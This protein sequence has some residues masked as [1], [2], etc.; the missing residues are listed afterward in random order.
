V[1]DW[2]AILHGSP[3]RAGKSWPSWPQHDQT[4]REL[5]EATLESGEWSSSRGEKAIRLATEFAAFQDARYGIPLANGSL[6]LEAALAACEVGEGDEVIVPALTFVT[7]ANAVLAVN[8]VPIFADIDPDS[9]CIDV[10]AVEAAITDRTRA[11]IP[12]HLA[13]TACDLDALVELCERHDLALIEDCAHAHGTRWKGRGVG[14]FGSFGS[15]SFQEG[16]LMTAG[17]GGALIT[18]D[19]ALRARAWSYANCG[20]PEPGHWYDHRTYGT[21]MRMTEWQGA[22]LQAQLQRLPGQNRV[23]EERA[24]LLDS[25]LAEIPGLRP[26][27]G[28]PR[29]DR[30]SRY[31]YIFHYD[32]QEFA[33]LPLPGFILALAHEGIVAG[34]S[35]PSLNSLELFRDSNFG[36]RMQA[37]APRIDYGS[38]SLPQAEKAAASTV[39]LD[40]RMLL[41]GPDDVLDVVRAVSRIRARAGAVRLRTSKPVRM[42]GRIVRG[43]YRRLAPSGE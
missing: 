40:H 27:R 28:D 39:W 38:I 22:V 10:A 16:K 29:M 34:Q 31:S 41:A 5:L 17:E 9:L 25:E 19:E 26:Q 42:G 20:R 43:T 18:N 15:F 32:P 4:D 11:V 33:A 37:S 35:Y 24:R 2:P 14:S 1:G 30:R 21:N 13:G 7:T 8:G 3:V 12:V 36:R 6:S 23:R